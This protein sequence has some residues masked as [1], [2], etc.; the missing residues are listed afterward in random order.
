MKTNNE[1]KTELNPYNLIC[2]FKRGETDT[3]LLGCN[4]AENSEQQSLLLVF[5]NC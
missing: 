3:F 2:R 4:Y 1:P 5:Q